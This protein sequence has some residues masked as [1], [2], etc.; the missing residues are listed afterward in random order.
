MA[1]DIISNHAPD[2]ELPPIYRAVAIEP[3]P[4][5]GNDRGGAFAHA[6]SLAAA[7][8]EAGTLVWTRRV[9]R[10]D[11]AVVLEP[12]EPLVQSLP[13]CHVASLG[14]VDALG[15][16][17][18]PNI[19]VTFGWPDRVEVNGA[20]VGGVRLTVAETRCAEAI[21]DWMVLG[22]TIQVHGYPDDDDPGLRPDRTA[23]HEEGFG[24]VEVVPLLESFSRHFLA[25]MNTWQE[26]GFDQVRQAWLTRA[27]G[28]DDVVTLDLRGERLSGVFTGIDADGGLLLG[29]EDG[30]HH[31]PLSDALRD[32]TWPVGGAS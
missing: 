11:A 13:V 22:I 3:G 2:P 27:T 23:L 8:A 15:A 14:L 4:L 28:L 16:L 20:T 26:D 18:P 21:P 5:V 32:P 6:S 30:I 25:W 29:R 19:P 7:G 24:E 1:L 17:G 31:I 12:N 9:D 10:L